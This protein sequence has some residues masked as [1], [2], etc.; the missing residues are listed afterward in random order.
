MEKYFKI[1]GNTVQSPCDFLK[2]NRQTKHNKKQLWRGSDRSQDNIF[3]KEFFRES[4]HL[5]GQNNIEQLF[6]LILSGKGVIITILVSYRHAFK[7]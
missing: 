5:L 6:F 1:N 2:V 4:E 3:E 7:S